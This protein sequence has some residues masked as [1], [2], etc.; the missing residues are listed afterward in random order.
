SQERDAK[1]RTKAATLASPP[2]RVF[3]IGQNIGDMNDLAFKQDAP[4]YRRSVDS[5]GVS[6]D[7]LGVFTREPVARFEVVSFALRSTYGYH[8]RLAKARCRLNKRVQNGL[9]I[10]GRAADDLE[11][12]GGGGL[13]LQRF[14]QLIEQACVLDSDHSLFRKV[15][16]KL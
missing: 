4:R 6:G 2:I 1:N 7:E 15:V 12:V 8:V 14:A 9:Q 13:L 11:H 16:N 3:R 10:E 5:S